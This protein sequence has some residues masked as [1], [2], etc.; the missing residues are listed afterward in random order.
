VRIEI[1]EGGAGY[2]SPPKVT[3]KGFEATPLEVKLHFE[4]DLETNG[5]IEA[6]EV[7]KKKKPAKSPPPAE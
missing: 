5:S 1:S 6:I 2:S 7:A 3:I 4:K